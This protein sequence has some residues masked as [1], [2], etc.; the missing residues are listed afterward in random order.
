MVTSQKPPR[1]PDIPEQRPSG[2]PKV[3]GIPWGAHFCLF[4]QT[5]TDLLEVALPF[6]EAGL[7]ANERCFWVTGD[8]VDPDQALAEFRA[9]VGKA[10]DYV[11]AGA[12]EIRRARDWYLSDNVFDPDRVVRAWGQKLDEALSRGFTGLRVHANESWLTRRTWNAFSQYEE[13]IDCALTGKRLIGLCTYPLDGT[14]GS[15]VFDVSRTHQFTIARRNGEWEILETAESIGAKI[16]L[17]ELTQRLEAQVKERTA[18]LSEA[19]SRLEESE[20]LYGF[21]AANMSDIIALYDANLRRVYTSPSVDRV[22]GY[23]PEP[24]TGVHPDDLERFRQHLHDVAGGGPDT[25]TYRHRHVDGSWRWLEASSR[26]V[27]LDGKTHVIVVSRDVSKRIELEQRLSH[28]QKMEAV[29]RLAGGVAH[30]FNNLLTAIYGYADLASRDLMKEDPVQ[31]SVDEIKSTT[32]RAQRVARQLLTFS[33]HDIR[34]PQTV[35]VSA[36]MLGLEGMLH[37]LVRDSAHLELNGCRKP[38]AV[39]IDPGQL[40][41]IFVNLVTNARDATDPGGKISICCDQLD[42]DA[43]ESGVPAFVRKGNYGRLRVTD[44]GTGMSKEVKEQAFDPFFTT[45]PSGIGTGLGLST[46]FGIA[47]QAGGYVWIDSEEGEGTTVAVL[48]PLSTAAVEPVPEPV[49]VVEETD[50]RGA[51]ILVVEDEEAVRNFMARVLRRSG[52]EVI[53]VASPAQ[54]LEFI[55]DASFRIDLLISDVMMPGMNGPALVALAQRARPGLKA[56]LASG[57]T[58]DE[59]KLRGVGSRAEL[60]E[61]PFRPSDLIAR[62]LE[63]LRERQPAHTKAPAAK[64]G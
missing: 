2:I 8:A 17:Q 52:A 62:V 31:Q 39:F 64:R 58:A 49:S 54:A 59:E 53:D 63:S 4:Y 33:R 19:Y 14:S 57:Y 35:D 37:M 40:E 55:G 5:R 24:M 18:K 11:D 38:L 13:T 42:T 10:D 9:G 41:Q 44:T 32:E 48:L 20:G 6:L 36:L 7:K 56:L 61:K 28:A 46:V 3:G 34:Q 12:I 27:E 47:K 23:R 60:L 43:A 26:P 29:G 22:L 16:A 1:D 45:K 50:L 30:D 51:S 15:D 21:I 25:L